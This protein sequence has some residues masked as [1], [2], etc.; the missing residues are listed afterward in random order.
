M[1]QTA[2]DRM[3]TTASGRGL[4]HVLESPGVT[5]EQRRALQQTHRELARMESH[6]L[7]LARSTLRLR[8]RPVR[9]RDSA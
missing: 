4:L 6:M 1:D 2:A 8:T 7:A 3:G 9:L 5:D